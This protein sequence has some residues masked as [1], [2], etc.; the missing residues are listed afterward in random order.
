MLRKII[1]ED[2]DIVF[3]WRNTLEIRT[4]MI[5]HQKISMQEHKSWFDHLQNSET[6]TTLIYME[7]NLRL[8]V[9]SLDLIEDDLF[10]WGFYS[11]PL[12]L[13]AQAQECV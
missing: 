12:A 13:L 7:K 3:Q 4:N 9:V 11:S 5:N 10:E 8:G 6:K 1:K 2:L